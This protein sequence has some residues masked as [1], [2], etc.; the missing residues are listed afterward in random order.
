M[1]SKLIY[2][3]ATVSFALS[4]FSCSNSDELS[5]QESNTIKEEI[6]QV[7]VDYFI[8]ADDA[9]SQAFELR[10]DV[11]GY[12]KAFNGMITDTTYSSV[13][14]QVE[15][16]IDNGQKE[17]LRE[18][19]D[20][21]IFPLSK[22][23]ASCTFLFTASISVPNQKT[24]IIDTISYGGNLTWVFKKFDNKWKVVHETGSAQFY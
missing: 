23:A 11:K 20:V 1:R 24:G 15:E 5:E 19:S 16:D 9:A 22:S 6:N 4:I 21:H 14:K 18:F 13:R 12:T 8:I 10:A 2:L 3:I 7:V 17:L